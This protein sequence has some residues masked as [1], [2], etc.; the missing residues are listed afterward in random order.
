[1]GRRGDAFTPVNLSAVSCL[2][3]LCLVMFLRRTV[4]HGAGMAGDPECELTIG[5]AYKRPLWTKEGETMGRRCIL[6]TPRLGTSKVGAPSELTAPYARARTARARARAHAHAPRTR[7]RTRTRM[8]KYAH[9][10]S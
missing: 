2:C 7:T 10:R 1:M 9:A 4:T 5:G 6:G 8:P 3:V